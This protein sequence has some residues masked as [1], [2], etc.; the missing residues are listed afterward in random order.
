MAGPT[1]SVKALTPTR[2]RV[3]FSTPMKKDAALTD[4]TNYALTS[5]K[6]NPYVFSIDPQDEDE[7]LYVDVITSEHIN[8]YSWYYCTIAT[9]PDGPTDVDDNHLEAPD[10]EERYTGIG[11]IP[12]VKIVQAVSK[13][14]ADV[15]FSEPMLEYGEIWDSTRYTFDKGLNVLGILSV[16]GDTVSL[17]TSDQIPGELYTLTINNWV[18][19]GG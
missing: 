6:H 1:I 2:V 7:P 17:A 9:A 4:I 5:A 14:R 11:N 15:V 10:N 3:T 8:G 13:N 16:S 19:G 18:G 12:T